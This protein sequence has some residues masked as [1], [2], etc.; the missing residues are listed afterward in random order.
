MG[1]SGGGGGS[2]GGGKVSYP[3]YVESAHNRMLAVGI[4]GHKDTDNLFSLEGEIRSLIN[5]SWNPYYFYN[6]N[7]VLGKTLTPES[8]ADL[9]EPKDDVD[10]L[11]NT[12]KALNEETEWQDKVFLATEKADDLF[13]DTD[14]DT[15]VDAFED[16]QKEELLRS[17]NIFAGGMAD[18][19]AVVSSAFPM[20]VALL[21]QRKS[22]A[23][24]GFEADLRLRKWTEKIRYISHETS[25]LMQAMFQLI[26]SKVRV[27]GL[28][29]EVRRMRYVAR[30][31]Y[32]DKDLEYAE[33]AALWNL[34]LY[35]HGANLLA[36]PSGGT[37]VPKERK[38][39]GGSSVAGGVGGALSGAAAGIPLA[40]P[41]A[42]LSVIIGAVLGGVGG[43]ISA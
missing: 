41:T 23:I 21:A 43:A 11:Q 1:S 31:E 42:G 30:Q 8:T 3:G 25:Q 9:D 36:A 5:N 35:Q 34:Q 24:E 38:I 37:L 33:D 16:R 32:L 15:E 28:K 39:K 17:I 20:G 2:S 19:N 22:R 29:G 14:V 10:S 27:I 4:G 26:D 12:I 18:V 40:G 6:Y 7:T 13:T